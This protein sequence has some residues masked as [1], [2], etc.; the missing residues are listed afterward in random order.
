MDG[1]IRLQAKERKVLLERVR[2]GANPEERLRAHLLLLLADGWQWNVIVAVLFTSSSTINRWRQR[3]RTG[4]LADVFDVARPA[5]SRLSRW[6]IT[7]VLQWVTTRSPT[8]F[9]FVRSRWTCATIV[10]LLRED[11]GLRVG[12]ETV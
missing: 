11:H 1:S 5:P 2:R 10:V 8:D 9:G 12:R 6:W 4:G 3:F 7:V